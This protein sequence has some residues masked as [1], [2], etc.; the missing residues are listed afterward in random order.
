[1]RFIL[2]LVIGSL[3]LITHAREVETRCDTVR[4]CVMFRQGVAEIDSGF[5]AN[6][7]VLDKIRRVL[8]NGSAKRVLIRASASPEGRSDSNKILARHRADALTAYLAGIAP[9]PSEISDC[10]TDWSLLYEKVAVSDYG[11]SR[12]ACDIIKN[13]PVWVFEGRRVVDSRKRRLMRLDRGNIWNEMAFGFFPSL[14]YAECCIVTD[15]TDISG[16]TPLPVQD[17]KV[18]KGL[19]AE[20]NKSETD[21]CAATSHEPAFETPTYEAIAGEKG[22]K[23]FVALKTN[24]LYDAALV[25]NIGLEVAFAGS[26]SLSADWM[27][28]WWSNNASHRFWRVSG[29]E[30]ELRKWLSIYPPRY[31]FD[32]KV[33]SGHH[34]GAYYQMLTYDIEFG[35]T[36]YLGDR[37]THGVGLSYGY[38]LPV[39][40]FLSFDFSIGVG[41]LWGDYKKYR[42]MDDCYVWDS[43]SKRSWFGPTK[44]GISL[45]YI[46][47]GRKAR[48]GGGR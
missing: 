4:A 45:V 48:K 13:T 22:S 28:A 12:E 39:G 31:L 2:A 42:P 29:G 5:S 37:W 46:L 26:W 43:T 19:I 8:E 3:F 44:A 24:M 32:S 36:G 14:R 35:G 25:P 7:Q 1:M 21:T 38:S 17:K 30:V 18:D 10:D 23:V 34:I 41:Y 16:E 11:W 27:Y 9:V 20:T 33:F 47:G 6:R 40:R 15:G